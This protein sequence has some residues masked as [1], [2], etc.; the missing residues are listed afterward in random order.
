MVKDRAGNPNFLDFYELF[1]TSGDLK[2]QYYKNPEGKICRFCSNSFP[3]VSFNTLPHVVPE[4]FGRNRTS[5][6][7][8]CDSCNSK[9]QKHESDTSTMVQHYLAILN[10]KSKKGVPIFKSRKEHDAFSTTLKRGE[11]TVELNFGS[12]LTDFQFDEENKKLIVRLRTRRFSP[13]SIYKVFLKIGISLLPQEA[14]EINRHFLDFLNSDVPINNGM[15][16]WFANRYMLKTKYFQTPEANLYKAKNTLIGN[17]VYPEY[18][19]HIKF[20][21]VIFQYCLPIS[22]KNIA[23]YHPGRHLVFELFPAFLLEDISKLKK[24]GTHNFNMDEVGKVSI[25]DEIVFYYDRL[26]KD[27]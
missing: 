5:S 17:T 10:I 22:D 6:N 3:E 24:I 21:N 13:F 8:E 9:F 14:L 18:V 23:E 26:D 20:A 12:N 16:I 2:A 1:K 27:V 4:L 19:V 25:T 11:R 15:Q 7:F